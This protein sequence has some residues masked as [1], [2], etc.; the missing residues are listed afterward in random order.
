MQDERKLRIFDRKTFFTVHGDDTGMVARLYGGNGAIKQL[1]RPPNQL[2][3]IALNRSLFEQLLRSVLVDNANRVVE[4]W[5]GHGTVWRMARC[6]ASAHLCT[7]SMRVLRTASA[8]TT[9]A[10]RYARMYCA[11]SRCSHTLLVLLHY[12]CTC[13]CMSVCNLCRTAS[14]GCL[15]A[16]EDEL[17]SSVDMV[18]TPIVAAV[19]SQLVDNTRT[20]GLAFVDAA[21]RRLGAAQFEDDEQLCAL[22]RALVQLGAKEVVIPQVRTQSWPP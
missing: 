2:A 1:G 11:A 5:E 18:D 9:A 19:M 4:L 17:F 3:S 15:T 20:V 8:A 14:P 21:C 12:I 22:E 10:L 13:T 6:A 7:L 16:F